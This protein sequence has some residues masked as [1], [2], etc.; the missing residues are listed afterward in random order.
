MAVTIIHAAVRG[1]GTFA[2]GTAIALAVAAVPEGLPTA[3]T[4]ALS[5]GMQAM[6]THKVLL[7]QLEAVEMLGAVNV[8][9]SDKTGTLTRNRMSVVEI[10]ASDVSNVCDDDVFRLTAT[11]YGSSLSLYSG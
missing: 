4:V 1:P 9:C 2:R 7:R 10:F 6:L 5:D 3:A 11:L 8:I